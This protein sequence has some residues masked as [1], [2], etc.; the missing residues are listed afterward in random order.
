MF[1]LTDKLLKPEVQ[2]TTSTSDVDRSQSPNTAVAME[3]IVVA[4]EQQATGN[5]TTII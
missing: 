5:I 2:V 4:R 1:V 3:T